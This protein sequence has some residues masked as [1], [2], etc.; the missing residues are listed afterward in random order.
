M[1]MKAAGTQMWKV[2]IYSSG[3][4]GWVSAWLANDTLPSHFVAETWKHSGH[5]LYLQ[6]SQLRAGRKMPALVAAIMHTLPADVCSWCCQHFRFEPSMTDFSPWLLYRTSQVLTGICL[7]RGFK[8][9][10]GQ[11][12][13]SSHWLSNEFNSTVSMEMLTDEGRRFQRFGAGLRQP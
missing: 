9:Y 3:P 12:M 7:F 13:Q 10:N 8:T 11:R 5:L 2:A 4:D 1:E 6:R